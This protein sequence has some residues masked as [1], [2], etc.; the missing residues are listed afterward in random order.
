MNRASADST[1]AAAKPI[2]PTGTN[3]THP[4]NH[5]ARFHAKMG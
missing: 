5:R 4:R 2:I 1:K 3:Q